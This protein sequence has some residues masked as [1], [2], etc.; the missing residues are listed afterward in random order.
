L[1]E[2]KTLIDLNAASGIGRA[3]MIKRTGRYQMAFKPIDSNSDG[4]ITTVELQSL[5]QR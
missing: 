3:A 4:R 5:Q 2:F 1:S